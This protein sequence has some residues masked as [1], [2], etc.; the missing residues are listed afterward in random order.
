MVPNKKPPDLAAHRLS[1]EVERPSTNTAEPLPIVANG[2]QQETGSGVNRVELHELRFKVVESGTDIGAIEHAFNP[3][4]ILTK[5]P[6]NDKACFL[7]C[8][9]RDRRHACTVVRYVCMRP[10][11]YLRAWLL[12][13]TS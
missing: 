13:R 2:E 11:S 7:G 9:R 1:L 8:H 4:L 5:Q 6:T 12:L 10:G 3:A